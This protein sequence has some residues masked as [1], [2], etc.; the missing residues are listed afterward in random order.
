VLHKTFPRRRRYSAARVIR[1]ASG[2]AIYE[3]EPLPRL[4][5]H[6][7]AAFTRADPARAEADFAAFAE[8]C[9]LARNAGRSASGQDLGE[10]PCSLTER[11]GR[12]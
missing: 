7:D 2:A 10:Q 4:Y 8:E 3:H 9:D 5:D 12:L 6:E 11:I 1:F